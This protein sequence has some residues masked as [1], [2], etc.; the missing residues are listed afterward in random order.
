M[1]TVPSTF[2]KLPGSKPFN[3]GES[4][5]TTLPPC[6]SVCKSIGM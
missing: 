4:G 1:P 3:C 6:L 2:T 5:R